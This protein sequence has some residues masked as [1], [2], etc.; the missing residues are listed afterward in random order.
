MGRR[1][2]RP[3]RFKQAPVH[4]ERKLRRLLLDH[5]LRAAIRLVRAGDRLNEPVTA[6][7][8]EWEP[9]TLSQLRTWL[10]A[11]APFDTL[12][13]LLRDRPTLIWHPFVY[14][15]VTR[16]RAFPSTEED[17]DAANRLSRADWYDGGRSAARAEL[18]RLIAAWV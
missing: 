11:G 3:L 7:K 16:F 8:I 12:A 6:L 1:R 18:H 4:P 2:P 5:R 14:W 13:K 17:A 10:R 15:Q 9:S